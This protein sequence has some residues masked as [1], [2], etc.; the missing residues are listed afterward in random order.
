MGILVK[1]PWP[2]PPHRNISKQ[3]VSEQF[4]VHYRTVERWMKSGLPHDTD[5]ARFR[6]REVEDWL[7][8][9]SEERVDG[10]A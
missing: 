4:G 7:E 1:G 2:D 3:Q 8:A 10:A 5:P 9:R 6:R